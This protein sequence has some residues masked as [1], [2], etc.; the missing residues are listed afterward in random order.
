MVRTRGG[1]SSQ[2]GLHED[3]VERRCPT[4]S[5]RRGRVVIDDE[6]QAE[7]VPDIPAPDIP[8]VV[9]QVDAADDEDGL[10]GGPRDTSVLIS[11]ADH[12]ACQLWTGEVFHDYIQ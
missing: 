11:Y 7:A 10:P 8:V 9:P 2:G 12:V 4:A 5:A 3:R 1:G 6:A